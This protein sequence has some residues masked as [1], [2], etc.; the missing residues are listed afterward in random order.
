MAG[1]S[2]IYR[3]RCRARNGH[4]SDFRLPRYSLLACKLSWIWPPHNISWCW[5][6]WWSLPNG[7]LGR[8]MLWRHTSSMPY[9]CTVSCVGGRWGAIC[10][11]FYSG[12]TWSAILEFHKTLHHDAFQHAILMKPF[13]GSSH[14]ILSRC[15]LLCETVLMFHRSMPW[16]QNLLD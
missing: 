7:R 8:L 14:Y 10:L 15:L 11:P 2:A 9:S 4:V 12:E 3:C 13:N 16:Q 1:C 5:R 6:W